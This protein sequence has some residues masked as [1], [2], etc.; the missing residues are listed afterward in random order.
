MTV[1][2]RDEA[3]P[4]AHRRRFTWRHTLGV[5]VGI[6][7][8]VATFAFI[9]PKIAD[10]R[11]VWGVVKDVS[12]EW[13]L[14]LAA[15]TVVNLLTFAPPWLALLPGLRFWQALMMT[16]A[17]TALSLVVPGGAAVG[18]ATA[19]GM[20]RRAGFARGTIARSVT[21]VSLW[22]QLANLAYPIVAVFLLTIAGEE[23]TVLA[24]V[25]FVGVAIFGVVVAA[26]V[27][28]LYSN[29]MAADIGDLAARAATNVKGRFQREPVTWGG[30]SFERFRVDVVD[31][32]ERRWHVLT[33]ATLAGSLSVFVVLLVSLRALQVPSTE[34]TAVEAFAAWSLARILGSIPITPGGI[35]IVELS[36]TAALIGFGGNN[37][38]VV[39]AV[40][41]FR[42]LTI[43]PTLVLGILAATLWQRVVR[44]ALE[45]DDALP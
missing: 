5:G 41:V 45:T 14:A 31:V 10:Y 35:G 27:L 8:V 2:G 22:N 1:D 26:L 6:A 11:D 13:A 32:L 25:A 23:T 28:I 34:V 9:L 15:V 3:Q 21:L 17:T 18:I 36:L 44:G 40:L 20:L 39:A 12:W 4:T 29:R 19:Y 43:V 30:S 33:L 24:T 16:Q 37:A 7:V 42:F 38:G